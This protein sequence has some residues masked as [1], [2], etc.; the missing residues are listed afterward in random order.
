M[1][2]IKNILY[3][4]IALE[5]LFKSSSTLLRSK[6]LNIVD[7]SNGDS[8]IEHGDGKDAWKETAAGWQTMVNKYQEVGNRV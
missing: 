3:I 6:L 2:L 1:Q 7:S 5:G 4:N 8:V